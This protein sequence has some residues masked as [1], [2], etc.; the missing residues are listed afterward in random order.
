[1]TTPPL[2]AADLP[3][4][5]A[6]RLADR[7]A[8]R[9]ALA[10]LDAMQRRDLSTAGAFLAPDFVMCFPGGHTMRRLE[11]LVQ[12]SGQRYRHVAKR[13]E[14]VDEAP[15][16]DG[17]GVY[18]SGTL[19]GVWADGSAFEGIRF[20]DRFEVVGG[21]IRRQDVWNDVGGMTSAK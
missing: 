16:D 1:M 15:I 6:T 3:T 7:P 21:R 14:R 17:V 10:F 2:P 18:C 12:R 5:I 20:I 11:E 8:S 19:Y 4:A 13:F 9:V